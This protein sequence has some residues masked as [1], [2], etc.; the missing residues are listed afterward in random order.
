[1]T[2]YKLTK[3]VL[4]NIEILK[5]VL[6][7]PSINDI[8]I[9]YLIKIAARK[10]YSEAVKILLQCPN[11]NLDGIIYKA[12][13]YGHLAVVEILLQED[14]GL[15]HGRLRVDPSSEDNKAIKIASQNNNLEIV[16]RLLQDQRVDPSS[17]D[18]YLIQAASSNGH[19]KMVNRL[20][21]DQRVDPSANSNWAIQAASSIGHLKMVNRLLEDDRVDPSVKGDDGRDAIKLATEL[22]QE[23]I[24]YRLLQDPRVYND[25]DV[26]IKYKYEINKLKNMIKNTKKILDFYK[27]P[28]DVIS[29]EIIPFLFNDTSISD[30][31]PVGRPRKKQ[32]I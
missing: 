2:D 27:I 23:H 19:L 12:V 11:I 4:S 26:Q 16:D 10:G 31:K 20:L 6:Q 15:S 5:L 18:N 13:E 14:Q 28:T 22:Q 30:P 8:N 21:K 7:D 29:Y 25:K 17:E 24:I 9:N 1:M 3:A 32:R